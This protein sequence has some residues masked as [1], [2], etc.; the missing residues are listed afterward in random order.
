MDVE[1]TR[2]SKRPYVRVRVSVNFSVRRPEI[3]FDFIRPEVRSKVFQGGQRKVGVDEKV[4]GP[5]TCIVP[6]NI[7]CL[8]KRLAQL[9]FEFDDVLKRSKERFGKLKDELVTH[10]NAAS[11]V[12]KSHQIRPGNSRNI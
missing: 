3:F 12:S 11:Q 1:R 7:A 4:G 8:G 9:V 10:Q 2:I 5:R 6:I